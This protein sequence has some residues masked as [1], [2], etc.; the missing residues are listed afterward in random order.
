MI[1]T[2]VVRLAMQIIITPTTTKAIPLCN[3]LASKLFNLV[4]PKTVGYMIIDHAGG[5]H[6]GIDNFWS[7]KFKT[8][9]TKIVTEGDCFWRIDWNI[10]QGAPVILLWLAA[11]KTPLIGIK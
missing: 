6:M 2:A 3:T 4:V 9:L 7:D 10:M 5:L 1:V 11:N 8:T